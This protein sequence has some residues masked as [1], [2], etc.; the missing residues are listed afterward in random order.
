MIVY[1]GSVEEMSPLTSSCFFCFQCK[2]P[3]HCTSMSHL[4]TPL[5]VYL[6]SLILFSSSNSSGSYPAL[7]PLQ[8]DLGQPIHPSLFSFFSPL[9]YFSSCPMCD[10]MDHED[11]PPAPPVRMSSTIFSGDGKDYTLLT[12]HSSK[13]LPSVPEERKPRS[14]IISIFSGAE[15]GVC[16]C[17]CEEFECEYLFL[18][19]VCK[20]IPQCIHNVL[21]LDTR[22]CATELTSAT[23]IR[24]IIPTVF[25]FHNCTGSH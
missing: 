4:S 19:T 17:V 23:C 15:K 2:L 16:V 18:K 9:F 7:L 3:M 6:L 21:I 8:S 22:D 20:Y 13:P 25:F 10:N 24:I 1:W 14:K 11:K 5:C 12:N